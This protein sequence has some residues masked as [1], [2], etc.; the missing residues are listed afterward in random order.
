[1]P[2]LA[3]TLENSLALTRISVLRSLLCPPSLTIATTLGDVEAN[4]AR[5][6]QADLF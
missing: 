3:S 4:A 1:M 6:S 5:S 2:R